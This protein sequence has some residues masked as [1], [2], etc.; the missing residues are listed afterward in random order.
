MECKGRGNNEELCF[1][2]VR[3]EEPTST[4]TSTAS[5]PFGWYI[6]DQFAEEEAPNITPDLWNSQGGKSSSGS[7]PHIKMTK[8]RTPPPPPPPRTHTHPHTPPS[9]TMKSN[10]KPE[11]RE[12]HL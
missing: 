6:P 10:E 2:P 12:G 7:S 5:P 1:P 4:S 8:Q 3:P 9:T 11:I